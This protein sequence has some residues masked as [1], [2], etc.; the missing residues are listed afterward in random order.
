MPSLHH[1]AAIRAAMTLVSTVGLVLAGVGGSQAEPLPVAPA[2]ADQSAAATGA[3]TAHCAG[4]AY[5]WSTLT[6]RTTSARPTVTHMDAFHL[7]PRTSRTATLWLQ[8]LAGTR[9][10]RAH[11]SPSAAVTRAQADTVLRDAERR[12]AGHPDLAAAGRHATAA[13]ERVH[14][15]QKAAADDRYVVVYDAVTVYRGTWGAAR[16]HDGA[17]RT[18]RGSWTSF[19]DHAPH[20]AVCK[21]GTVKQKSRY[22]RGSAAAQ[23]CAAYGWGD[24]L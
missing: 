13:P 7:S 17:L 24:L 1:R 16:C 2:A 4:T 18:T 19:T 3:S 14:V 21:V 6:T 5:S 10:I 12:T 15:S 22:A 20:V 11:V 9:A 23:A 8:P